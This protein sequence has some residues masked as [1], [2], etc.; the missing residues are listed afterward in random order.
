MVAWAIN[1]LSVVADFLIGPAACLDADRLVDVVA[2]VLGAGNAP[3]VFRHYLGGRVCRAL[4]A[5][6]S[7]AALQVYVGV[8][9]VGALLAG[10]V[11]S[12]LPSWLALDPIAYPL[13]SAGELVGRAVQARGVFEHLFLPR[14]RFID[15]FLLVGGLDLI[16][17]AVAASGVLQD[18]LPGLALLGHARFFII[19]TEVVIRAF[20][21]PGVVRDPVQPGTA[22]ENA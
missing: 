22:L 13:G 19:G 15:A 8:V 10:S 1:A 7:L 21:A 20:D 4:V 9:I 17:C 12:H 3:G 14:A 5:L 2:V 16:I 18:D 11:Y 6:S